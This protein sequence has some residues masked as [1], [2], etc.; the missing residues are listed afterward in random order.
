MARKQRRQNSH[1]HTSKQSAEQ[2]SPMMKTAMEYHRSGHLDQALIIYEQ[3]YSVDP[4]N[5]EINYLLAVL[6][7]QLQN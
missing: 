3:A 4:E 6:N 5:A 1:R 7:N 2:Q